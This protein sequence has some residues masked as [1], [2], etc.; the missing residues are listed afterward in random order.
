M[1]RLAADGHQGAPEPPRRLPVS[2]FFVLFLSLGS[3]FCVSLSLFF[4]FR[5][6]FFHF[7]F[8]FCFLSFCHCTFVSFLSR[9]LLPSPRPIPPLGFVLPFSSLFFSALLILCSC[10]ASK[11]QRWVTLW[12]IPSPPSSLWPSGFTTQVQRINST[13]SV[14]RVLHT[15]AAHRHTI[16]RW[17]PIKPVFVF[18]VTTTSKKRTHLVYCVF[19][20]GESIK[21]FS[22]FLQIFCYICLNWY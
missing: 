17:Q 9:Q 4:C 19:F 18:H 10:A 16:L 20:G 13:V 22:E 6:L 5:T 15:T 14:T 7:I 1:W 3:Q 8:L 11:D 21:T 12:E 2:V